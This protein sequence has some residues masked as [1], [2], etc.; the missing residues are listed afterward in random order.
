AEKQTALLHN[1]KKTY[2]ISYQTKPTS[3]KTAYWQA[4]HR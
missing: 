2:S 4:I 1:K 3:L